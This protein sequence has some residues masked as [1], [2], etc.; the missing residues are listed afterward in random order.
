[1]RKRRNL[2]VANAMALVVAAP[3]YV[4]ARS[5]GAPPGNA[6]GPDG[7]TCF[8][9]GCH[10]G[11]LI[12]GSG[13]IELT[14]S[15]G[16]T[17]RPGE[18]HTLTVQVSDATSGVAF[19]GF[20]LAAR[21]ADNSQAG[22]LATADATTRVTPAAG[23]Q[24]MTH[25]APRADGTFSF[26]WTA[27]PAGSGPVTF[28]LAANAANGNGAPSGDRIHNR[29]VTVNPPAGERPIISQNGVLHG[30]TFTTAAGFGPNT[31]G[32]VFGTNI[33]QT[34]DEWSD[35]FVENAAPTRLGGAR[36]LVNGK[37]AF[38]SFTGRAQDFNA[39]TDQINFVFP[40]DEMR[41]DVQVVVET[42]QGQSDPVTIQLSGRAP[43]F[44]PFEPQGRRYAAAI[45]NDASAYIGPADLFG[46][47]PLPLP[48]P[49]RPARTGDV[50]QLF[51]TGF[52][53]TDPA[54]PIGQIPP[55]GTVANTV[56]PVAVR[57]GETPATVLFAG[58]SPFVGVYQI[59]I[60]L[61]ALANG[62][63]ELS[64]EIGGQRSQTGVFLAVQNP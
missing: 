42:D 20:Q 26:H 61:P 7:K 13:A 53:E 39:A 52:G 64:A 33:V 28:Y 38:L 44:F 11:T 15:S 47:A 1:M 35:N 45:M 25:S 3:L 63:H 55:A 21:L 31:F 29:A 40:A 54:V 62:D 5:G 17:Y 14:L 37:P 18:Q 58:L 16:A 19:Y 46:G 2:L 49:I 24:Y 22:S 34:T 12:E 41:G 27:P 36:V 57:L 30:A 8:Q 60:Q 48:V 6:G 51:G 59:V 23:I 32:T 50:I 56:D 43:A 4:I 9:A 10:S